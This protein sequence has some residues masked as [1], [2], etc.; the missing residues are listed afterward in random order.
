M[1]NDRPRTA[2]AVSETLGIF[3]L[4]IAAIV[5]FTPQ[6]TGQL[7]G[8][9]CGS[10]LGGGDGDALG[11]CERALSA[12]TMWVWLLIIVGV[13]TL[14]TGRVIDALERSDSRADVSSA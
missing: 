1:S 12:P 4:V 6:T 10:V 7:T 11:A 2:L 13:L 14:A 5:G 9:K 8:A 3:M